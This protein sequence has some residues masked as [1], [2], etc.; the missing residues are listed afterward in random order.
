MAHGFVHQS[1]GSIDIESTAGIGTTVHIF[2][3]RT[4][5]DAATKYTAEADVRVGGNETV[6]VVDDEPDILDNVATLLRDLGYRAL[7]ANN[8]DEALEMLGRPGQIDLLFTDV[9]MPGQVNATELAA[10]AR[11]IHPE[12]RVLL[13]SGYTANAVIHNGRLDE[14]V[15]LLSKPYSQVE[16]ARAVRNLLNRPVVLS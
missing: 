9:I 11:E 10:R 14:G 5:R 13:T 12:L 2:L 4:G 16:L 6:L 3:P 1:G 8:A 7:T 15:N